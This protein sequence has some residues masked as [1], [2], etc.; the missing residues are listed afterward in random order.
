MFKR[1]PDCSRMLERNTG[2][3]RFANNSW[4]S[5]CRECENKRRRSR[6]HRLKS[7]KKKP[8]P[9]KQDR[10]RRVKAM[11]K[12]YDRIAKTLDR[13][14]VSINAPADFVDNLLAAADRSKRKS[15]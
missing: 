1:C 7:M 10:E 14:G 9:K 12:K 3:F 6:Y 13:F 15:A 4:R 5:R 2:N 8:D 11:I